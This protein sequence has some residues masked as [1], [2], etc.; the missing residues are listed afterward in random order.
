MK[1]RLFKPTDANL[2]VAIINENKENMGDL[3]TKASLI[4][5][6]KN[7]N[8]WVAEEGGKIIGM[9]GLTDLNNGIGMVIS[10]CVRKL[11]QN[12]GIGEAL[13]KRIESEVKKRK[14]RKLLLLTH[15]ANK[16]MMSLAIKEDFIPEGTLKKHFKD[17][18]DVVYFSYFI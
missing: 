3:Y 1:I 4:K 2:C 6:S 9:I 11:F 8:Y 10:F 13:L 7:N 14:Y 18:K 5:S 17:G 15:V 12:R 16:R